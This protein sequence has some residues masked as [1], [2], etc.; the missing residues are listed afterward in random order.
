MLSSL[1]SNATVIICKVQCIY[2]SHVWL[3]ELDHREAWAQKNWCFW[4]VV[5]EKTLESPLD[6]KMKPINLK[7]NQLW[8]FIDMTDAKLEASTLWPPDVKSP[9]IGKDPDAGKDWRQEKKRM[10]RMRRLDSIT[11][12]MD[13][14]L[15]KL[16]EILRNREAWCA[17]VHGVTK[18]WPQLSD[19]TSTTC[20][21]FCFWT[22]YYV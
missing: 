17:A 5:L 4:P 15:S 8:I 3:W 22:P 12:S 9:L 14:N 2:C 7:G 11:D 13:M 6:C 18:S 10:Q 1:I 21:L 16:G 19:R 20:I